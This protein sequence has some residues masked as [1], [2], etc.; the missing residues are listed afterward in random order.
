MII[1]LVKSWTVFRR[2][3]GTQR[4]RFSFFWGGVAGGPGG[5]LCSRRRDRENG[6]L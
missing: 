2:A 3:P 4:S 5:P 6:P 1:H